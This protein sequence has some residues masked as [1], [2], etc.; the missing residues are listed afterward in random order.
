MA[1]P[2]MSSNAPP[3]QFAP[4]CFW[5][6]W[7]ENPFQQ[8]TSVWNPWIF[9]I[10]KLFLI[11][12]FLSDHFRSFLTLEMNKIVMLKVWRISY[13]QVFHFI[14]A[15]ITLVDLHRNWLNWCHFLIL[16]GGPLL[17]LIDCMIFHGVTRMTMSTV[18]FLLHLDS[19]ILYLQ[20]VFL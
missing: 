13:H 4:K 10:S 19:A 1:W 6:F 8:L 14:S 9:F 5:P 17:I 12:T 3:L 2:S 20:N 15:S 16:T 18:F 7:W 11:S